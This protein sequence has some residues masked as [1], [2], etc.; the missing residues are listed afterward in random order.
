MNYILSEDEVAIHDP[1]DSRKQYIDTNTASK[2]TVKVGSLW[3]R[4]RTAQDLLIC[5]LVSEDVLPNLWKVR[6]TIEWNLC[7]N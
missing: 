1:K 6:K 5:V 2:G 7:K 3:V 4:R